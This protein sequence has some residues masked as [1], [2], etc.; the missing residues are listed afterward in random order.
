MRSVLVLM[1]TLI[2]ACD[3]GILTII[4]GKDPGDILDSFTRPDDT[5]P[6]D[7]VPLESIAPGDTASDVDTDAQALPEPTVQCH[8]RGGG[9]FDRIVTAVVP[10]PDRLDWTR[11]HAPRVLAWRASET[12]WDDQVPWTTGT[13]GPA[14]AHPDASPGGTYTL[15]VTTGDPCDVDLPISLA[16][17]ADVRGSAP[18]TYAATGDTEPRCT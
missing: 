5:D 8:D 15:T 6:H 10:V 13:E 7:E 16:W 18:I 11:V 4:D 9:V 17:T 3:G 2:S 1:L 14:G 12:C